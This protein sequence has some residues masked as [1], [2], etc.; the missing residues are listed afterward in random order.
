MKYAD[1]SGL[2]E[3]ELLKKQR[4]LRQGMFEANMKNALG[5]LTNP[6]TI[7]EMRRD[8]ARIKTA[9]TVVT[10]GKPSTQAPA[11]AKKHAPVKAAGASKAKAAVKAAAKKTA[12][13]TTKAAPKAKA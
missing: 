3:K 5:Q 2:S 11:K 7:R 1:V 10:K 8:V 12:K 4:E 13:K 6:M 9:L